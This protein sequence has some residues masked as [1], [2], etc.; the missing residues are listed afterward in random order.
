MHVY[1]GT[2]QANPIATIL[3]LGRLFWRETMKRCADV[4]S[5]S[6]ST[7][8]LEGFIKFFNTE[9][10]EKIIKLPYEQRVAVHLM[11]AN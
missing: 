9:V 6:V 1:S 4:M 11:R 8:K 10:V 5:Q 2:F 7:K 3:N